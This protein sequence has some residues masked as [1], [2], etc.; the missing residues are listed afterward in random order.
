VV[1]HHADRLPDLGHGH[2]DRRGRPVRP[3]SSLRRDHAW[4]ADSGTPRLFG[5]L[6]AALA[7]QFVFDGVLL[8]LSG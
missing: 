2:A 1:R 7:V 5:A 4:P 8:V 3:H 6:L